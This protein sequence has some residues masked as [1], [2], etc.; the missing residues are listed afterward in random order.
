LYIL[1]LVIDII[2]GHQDHNEMLQWTLCSI[3]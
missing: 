1:F 2:K 3:T